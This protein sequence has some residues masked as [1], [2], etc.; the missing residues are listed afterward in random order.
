MHQPPGRLHRAFEH[1]AGPVVLGRAAVARVETDP[2]SEV[3]TD[4]QD[5]P[6]VAQHRTLPRWR[7]SRPRRRRSHSG[8]RLPVDPLGEVDAEALLRRA[9]PLLRWGCFPVDHES[10][11]EEDVS[12]PVLVLRRALDQGAVNASTSLVAAVG[13][14]HVGN[15]TGEMSLDLRP[16]AVAAGGRCGDESPDVAPR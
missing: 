8:G 3:P 1:G 10:T 16:D 2:W 9:D 15:P 7:R 6:L 14:H 12:R 4:E 13:H 11:L 5:P